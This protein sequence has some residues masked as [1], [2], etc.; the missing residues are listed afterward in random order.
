MDDG[1]LMTDKNEQNSLESNKAIALAFCDHFTS[2]DMSALSDLLAEDFR[3]RAPTAQIRNSAQL[4]DVPPLNSDPGL[5]KSQSI[6]IFV[7]ARS[8]CVG[9]AF[10]LTAVS[11]TGEDD[12]VALEAEGYAVNKFN[13]RIY[14]NHYLHLMRI[15]G[16]QIVELTEYQD[17]LLAYDVWRAP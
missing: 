14:D 6:E 3:W 15:R 8:R 13:G 17:T 5:T 7:F 9:G 11:L 12:R 10:S 1:R 4:K 16:R 2:G